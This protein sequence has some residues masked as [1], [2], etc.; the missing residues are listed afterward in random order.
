V[1]TYIVTDNHAAVNDMIVGAAMMIF[2][3]TRVPAPRRTPTPGGINFALGF[4]TLISPWVYGFS[5]QGAHAGSSLLVGIVVML[6]AGW[7]TTMTLQLRRSAGLSR[8]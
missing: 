6:F 5:T 1:L 2:G 3:L 7:S 8:M 4:W